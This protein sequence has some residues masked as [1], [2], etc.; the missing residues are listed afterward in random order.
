M[1][2][3]ICNRLP[4]LYV[5][6][7][8]SGAKP[9]IV[10]SDEI[11]IIGRTELEDDISA[12][13][14]AKQPHL[15]STENIKK[16]LSANNSCPQCR[17]TTMKVVQYFSLNKA[18]E[19]GIL[20][21]SAENASKNIASDKKIYFPVRAKAQLIEPLASILK[22][23]AF[24]F[25]A[26]PL[27]IAHWGLYGAEQAIR[28]TFTMAFKVMK[29]AVVISFA[30]IYVITSLIC[31]MGIE[32]TSLIHRNISKDSYNPETYVAFKKECSNSL[33]ALTGKIIRPFHQINILSDQYTYF[34]PNHTPNSI[35][36]G[37]LI[38]VLT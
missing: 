30:A 27:N 38:R 20:T 15:Y 4:S 8:D 32:M 29:I 10:A 14:C 7:I 24:K 36:H 35:Y 33:Y 13:T 9:L 21:E 34:K 6:Q 12:L 3:S 22:S 1:C 37:S 31:T 19:L 2:H 16:W 5:T 26:I 11:C 18:R 17:N 28:D 23:P 25:V